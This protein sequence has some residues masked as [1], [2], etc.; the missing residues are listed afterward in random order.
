MQF[1]KENTGKGVLVSNAALK[2][3]SIDAE[4]LELRL[5]NGV[6]ILGKRQMTASELLKMMDALDRVTFELLRVLV[7]TCGI[8]DCCDLECPFQ[9][10]R[11]RG[12]I[13][14][15]LLG[16]LTQ[17]GVCMDALYDLMDE[18]VVVYGG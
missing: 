2:L 16:L 11:K 15:N 12:D 1:V 14:D 4:E 9:A 3:S 7:N 6:A 8:C 13:P 5:E 10:E 18:E 17:C